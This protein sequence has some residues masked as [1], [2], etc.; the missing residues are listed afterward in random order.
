MIFCHKMLVGAIREYLMAFLFAR[1]HK[2]G[3]TW[4]VGYYV[5]GRFIRKR[6]GRSKTIAEK[7]RGTSRQGSREAR[8]AETKSNLSIGLSSA[9]AF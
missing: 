4:Y 5:D 9:A 8:Q 2:R 3:Q 6:I 1:K 7:A